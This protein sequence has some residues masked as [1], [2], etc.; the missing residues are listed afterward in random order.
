MSRPGPATKTHAPTIPYTPDTWTASQLAFHRADTL[1]AAFHAAACLTGGWYRRAV[2]IDYQITADN[3][4]RYMI[5]PASPPRP[6]RPGMIP[7]VPREGTPSLALHRRRPGCKPHQGC[8][9]DGCSSTHCAL[10]LA[11]PLFIH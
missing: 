3:N 7:Q 6:M 5:R 9:D 10:H 11:R 2:T 1:E 8:G 4:E